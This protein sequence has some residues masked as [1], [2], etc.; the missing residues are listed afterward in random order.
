[1]AKGD[2]GADVASGKRPFF[3]AV[4]FRAPN[5]TIFRNV[6]HVFF[7]LTCYVWC[8]G[9]Q[10]YIVSHCRACLLVCRLKIICD[11]DK[12]HLPWYAPARFWDYYPIEK[13]PPT[14][15]PGMPTAA[16]M[17]AIQIHI[18]EDICNDTDMVK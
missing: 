15:H 13:I 5:F 2:Y 17:T 4:G 7:S 11:A 12:P 6:V 1:M 16:P 8:S 3:L 14:P 10:F 9:P 18:S